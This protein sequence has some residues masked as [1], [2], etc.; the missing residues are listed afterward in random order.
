MLK[1]YHQQFRAEQR[2]NYPNALSPTSKFIP[3][4]RILPQRPTAVG[5]QPSRSDTFTLSA[6]H[7][8][9]NPK[10]PKIDP[11]PNSPFQQKTN[12]NN[13]DSIRSVLK[14]ANSPNR[15]RNPVRFAKQLDASFSSSSSVHNQTSRNNTDRSRHLRIGVGEHLL[16]QQAQS[17]PHTY[18]NNHSTEKRIVYTTR[19]RSPR[20]TSSK[21]KRTVPAY[22]PAIRSIVAPRKYQPANDRDEIVYVDDHGNEIPYIHEDERILRRRRNEK[23]SIVYHSSPHIAYE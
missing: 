17:S 1:S 21:S 13:T 4:D 10:A 7:H 18:R 12:S 23:K 8:R 20:N 11:R 14:Q 15:Q 6:R 5:R 9:I 3:A 2:D 22:H 16:H 19:D